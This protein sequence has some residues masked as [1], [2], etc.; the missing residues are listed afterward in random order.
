MEPTKDLLG[1]RAD[2][3]LPKLAPRPTPFLFPHCRLIQ[4]A[5]QKPLAEMRNAGLRVDF[6]SPEVMPAG[7][8]F[9]DY[10]YEENYLQLYHNDAMIVHNNWIK[11]HQDKKRRFQD[12]HLWSVEN[13]SFP[14]CGDLSDGGHGLIGVVDRTARGEHLI[15][16]T[17]VGV[18]FV[19]FAWYAS[20][21][22][23][24]RLRRR[25]KALSRS[26]QHL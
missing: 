8:H 13:T 11:G 12:Y 18:S 9:F 14:E 26:G 1:S 3:L 22:L 24:A 25:F 6:L 23:R 2:W 19:I 7:K 20:T 10:A 16:A 4:S 5:F 21:S 17:A 15:V